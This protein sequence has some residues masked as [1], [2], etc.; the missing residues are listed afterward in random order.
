[1]QIAFL[2]W[3]DITSRPAAHAAGREVIA[4]SWWSPTYAAL[5]RLQGIGNDLW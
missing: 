4:A 1:M 2:I 5:L 3:R